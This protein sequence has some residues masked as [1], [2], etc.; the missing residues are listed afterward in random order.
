[1]EP[2]SGAIA[3]ALTA[4]LLFGVSTPV[5]KLLLAV[6]DPWLTAGLLYLG[7]GLGL[8]GFR[9]LQRLASSR[10]KEAAFRRRDLPWLVSAIVSGGVVGPVLLMFGLAQV[11]AS[12]ASL[13]LNVEGVLTAVLARIVFGE[14]ISRRIALGMGAITIGALFLTWKSAEALHL[15]PGAL[16]VAGAC[17]A[18]AI[19]NNLTREISGGDP[20]EIRSLLWRRG[21]G[22]D[23]LFDRPQTPS[24]TRQGAETPQECGGAED[25][26]VIV[27]GEGDS[28]QRHQ[29][30]QD[31]ERAPAAERIADKSNND[32]RD[33]SAS[34]A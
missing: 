12:Q 21:D 31:D 29:N 3:G 33:R 25:H 30:A 4:A 11:S 26:K 2:A 6:A 10:P 22:Q 18:W 14:H 27:D 15:E 23:G 32:G 16:L 19:D 34:R 7:S 20:L 1:M 9:L 28:R 24:A 8:G 5:A 17:L 13:L